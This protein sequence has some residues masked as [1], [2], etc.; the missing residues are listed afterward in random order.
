MAKQTKD[1]HS[2]K[3]KK[4]VRG[5]NV[6]VS[7]RNTSDVELPS[8]AYFDSISA[9]LWDVMVVDIPD[10][11]NLSLDPP[12]QLSKTSNYKCETLTVN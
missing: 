6:A 4:S 11:W 9:I 10:L 1:K 2:K 8:L 5:K 7:D 12:D 3:Y